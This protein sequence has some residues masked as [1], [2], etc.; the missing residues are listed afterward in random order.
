MSNEDG[1]RI[2]NMFVPMS[3]LK[4]EIKKWGT[5]SVFTIKALSPLDSKVI[6]RRLAIEYNGLP[7][8]AFSKESQYIFERAAYI[9][10][11]IVEG[12]E[13]WTNADDCPDIDFLEDLYQEIIDWNATVQSNLK[14]N[15]YAKRG[16][17][18][19]VSD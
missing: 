11:S 16:T 14:K 6:A 10:Q 2:R 18:R 9:E 13:W 4:K 1:F 8:G 17:E 15:K 19:K 3:E 7:A 12:P 5:H